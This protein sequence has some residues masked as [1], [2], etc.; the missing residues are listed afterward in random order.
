M[1]FF[2]PVA[3]WRRTAYRLAMTPRRPPRPR[4][5]LLVGGLLLLLVAA[6]AGIALVVRPAVAGV[7]LDPTIPNGHLL[8]ARGLSGV[9]DP[10]QP[11]TPIAVD[12]VVTDGTTTYVQFHGAATYVQFHSTTPRG[13][14]FDMVP[15]L[16]DDTG[17]LVNYGWSAGP[18]SG[19]GVPPWARLLPPW[20]PWRPPAGPLRIVATLGPLPSTARAAV[21]Q[22]GNGETV[23]VPLN[24]AALRRVRPYAGPLMQ[25]A[26]LQ[27]RVVAA[28]DTGLVLGY[29]PFGEARGVAL[30][31]ARGHMVALTSHGS[32]CGGSG[33]ADTGPGLACRAVWTYPPQRRGARL[34]LT[35]RS[36]V[37]EPNASVSNA[38]GAGP[39]HLSVV[40]P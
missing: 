39:W 20:F 2:A 14:V 31:D 32:G 17:T 11:T 40:I 33:F 13:R 35:I 26:G 29:S 4:A 9:P 22:F 3:A 24:L 6:A 18:A 10:G 16:Y 5:S 7:P 23:R 34:T 8:I 27:L 30:T 28:R 38:V 36:F 12:R 21:L 15:Q 19:A 25:R 1:P 37:A